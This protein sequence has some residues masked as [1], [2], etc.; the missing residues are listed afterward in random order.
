M[1]RFALDSICAQDYDEYHVAVIDDGSVTP[2][3]S[4]LDKYLWLPETVSIYETGDSVE[5]KLIQGG[6]RH[7]QFINEA[8]EESDADVAIIL[9]DDDALY[10]GYLSALANYYT[11]NPFVAYSYGTVSVY[12]PLRVQD[13]SEIVDNFESDLNKNMPLNPYCQ[14]DA[15]QV[16]WRIAPVLA[17]GISFPSPQTAALD[18][19]VYQQLYDS[20][21][22]C[23]PNNIVAQ[24]KGVF[25]D[26]M[27]KR[28]NPFAPID[29]ESYG[30]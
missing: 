25:R 20:F 8:L 27:G 19:V 30:H 28:K 29:K 26:Q 3:R 6:S 13:Y 10:P 22:F 17:E 24:Y 5:Q 14:V 2:I 18:A 16:S 9:C 15:S 11:R 4:V 1:V 12:D 21:G 23:F 7:G